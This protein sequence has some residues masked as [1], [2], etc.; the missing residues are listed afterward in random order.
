MSTASI[1]HGERGL[2]VTG[3]AVGRGHESFHAALIDL[4]V[5]LVDVGLICGGTEG[6]AVAHPDA[7]ADRGG[8][9]DRIPWAST[10]R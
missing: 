10:T 3:L 4:L 7:A 6:L 2:E 5:D 1:R 9:E 8:H